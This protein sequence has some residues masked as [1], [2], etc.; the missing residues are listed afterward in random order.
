VGTPSLHHLVR[1]F[2]RA[3][4]HLHSWSRD[5]SLL[6]SGGDDK[7]VNI[8]KSYAG[9]SLNTQ[10][11][12][13]HTQNIFSV[14]FMPCSGD[15]TIVTAAGDSQVRVFD[16]EYAPTTYSSLSTSP[17]RAQTSPAA[18]ATPRR[19]RGFDTWYQDPAPGKIHSTASRVYTSHTDRAKRIVTE[20]SPHLFL[21]C[22]E[23]GTVRQFDLR[24]P[25][26]F[27]TRP[28]ALVAAS[29]M[30]Q[31]FEEDERNPPLI[32]YHQHGIDLNTISCST[33]QPH[34]IAL[35][36]SHLFC[37]L[38]DRRM[39][40]RDQLQEAGQKARVSTS[41][42]SEEHDGL[43]AATKCVRR[44]APKLSKN[45]DRHMQNSHVTSCKISDANPNEMV[46]SWSGDGVYLFDINHTPEPWDPEEE[47]KN[48]SRT[49]QEH[50]AKARMGKRRRSRSP[51]A[52]SSTEEVVPGQSM[53]KISSLVVELRGELFGLHSSNLLGDV[54][55]LAEERQKSY[56]AA[57][58]LAHAAL[59][60]M[61]RVNKKLEDRDLE[62]LR[63][64][65]MSHDDK[66]LHLEQTRRSTLARNRRNARAFVMAAGCVARAL[67]GFVESIGL[68]E[69]AFGGIAT[70]ANEFLSFRYH[71][72]S[73][74]LKFI[75]SGVDGLSE[76]ADVHYFDVYD[77]EDSEEVSE[78]VPGHQERLNAFLRD[79]GKGAQSTEVRDVDTN[80]E[81]FDTELSMV[82]AFKRAVALH[83]E[84]LDKSFN[85]TAKLFWGERVARA[86]LMKEA[87]GINFEFVER[88]FEDDATGGAWVEEG[89]EPGR[90]LF[91][92]TG[93]GEGED[94]EM[95]LVDDDDEYAE[96]DDL[97]VDDDDED[98][99]DGDEDSEDEGN[100]WFRQR[101]TRRGPVDP[102]APIWKHQR[103]YRGHCNVRTVKDV[104]FFGLNDEYVVS[105][106][107]C[108]H[109]FI[110]M[111][112]CLS[113]I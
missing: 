3:K 18:A 43:S 68:G 71:F 40:G 20:S 38:H 108:G 28:R 59:Q 6:A 35:G 10:I 102:D 75:E 107:D 98:G 60:Q 39:L 76:M 42:E 93:D 88:A 21:T 22:S 74:V 56:D 26:E 112:S 48:R 106:S 58:T 77:P 30:G 69:G 62:V 109:L 50:N 45:W 53:R 95:P 100:F 16:I 14:K 17:L 97:D 99:E 47:R 86:V 34:Y 31:Y 81:V 79:L 24:Q 37:F 96:D 72:L 73:A 36:G 33:S 80:E 4:L 15:R 103:V 90:P 84:S 61:Y 12:T 8:Y 110:C 7:Q 11:H 94:V 113:L 87:E 111:H 54:H 83:S 52:T 46:V 44:F 1:L 85:N 67:G 55:D 13:G 9:F 19:H 57:L 49:K 27:Y 2:G 105:G 32:S 101:R 51:S 82:T 64:L 29:P 41:S 63:L 91:G 25:S 70:G 104:N 65:R 89:S 23:D 66:S 92:E 78:P 5:G